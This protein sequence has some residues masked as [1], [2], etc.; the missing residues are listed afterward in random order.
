MKILKIL[1]VAWYQA[2][3]CARSWDLDTRD[4]FVICPTLWLPQLALWSERAGYLPIKR[5]QKQQNVNPLKS[6]V[7]IILFLIITTLLEEAK[8]NCFSYYFPYIR[9]PQLSVW[10][11]KT[12]IPN[13]KKATRKYSDNFFRLS[14]NKFD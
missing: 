3:C 2:L 8:Y 10:S 6:S 12:W 5:S 4:Q 7:S 9:S 14:Q 1:I 13:K 11:K